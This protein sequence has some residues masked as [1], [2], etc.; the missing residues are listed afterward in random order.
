MDATMTPQR[1]AEIEARLEG[2]TPGPWRVDPRYSCDV[3]SGDGAVEIASSATDETQGP[4]PGGAA[5]P[6]EKEWDANALFIAHARQDVPDLLAYVR[7]LEGL[8]SDRALDS[9]LSNWAVRQERERCAKIVETGGQGFDLTEAAIV[10]GVNAAIGA[11]I[12]SGL[13][14]QPL[15]LTE[16]VLR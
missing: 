4:Y 13:E 14:P 15:D 16:G 7:L 5:L 8:V 10:H 6:P 1:L 12:R 3:Q 2:V 11:A 9:D